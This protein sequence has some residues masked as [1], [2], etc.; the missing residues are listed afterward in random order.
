MPADKQKPQY[1]RA[2]THLT[3]VAGVCNVWC[4]EWRMYD[5]ILPTAFLSGVLI[6]LLYF[7]TLSAP[8]D[9]PSGTLVKIQ[10]GKS[11]VDVAQD[12]QQRHIVRSA[13]VLVALT[14][15]YGGHKAVIAGEYFFP[16]QQ[17]VF[18]IARR[19][20]SGDYELTPV[21][22]TIPEGANAREIQALLQQK[23]PDFDAD[24]F[25]KTAQ[26]KEGYLFPD[27]YF[28]L[29]GVDPQLVVYA[30]LENFKNKMLSPNAQQALVAFNKPL[31]EIITMAS[32]LEKEAPYTKDRK[33]IAGILWHRIA[34]GMPL[35]VDAVFPYIIGVNSLQLTQKQLKTDSPYNT[36][37]HKGLPPG[38]IANPGMDAL[39]A[40]MTPTKT[41]YVFSLSALH[42]NFHY[43]VTYACHLANQRK[44][45]P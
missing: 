38:P 40:A 24:S 22:V 45:L 23:I 18:T 30:L 32:L 17:S 16:G 41:N 35:Q 27:T 11:T 28:F 29:P 33:I 39:L 8:L 1:T 25:L 19:L 5:R 3:R 36:Y 2:R 37:L 21:R 9:F 34:V 13:L 4:R 43:C 14:K 12:L 26:P 7:V 31:V 42:G 6:F 10:K 20:A 44:Y 15:V